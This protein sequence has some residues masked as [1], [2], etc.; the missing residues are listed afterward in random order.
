MVLGPRMAAARKAKG[1][2]QKELAAKLD[3]V[4]G[5][6]QQYELGK[7]RP[8]V[9]TLKNIAD[10]LQVSVDSLVSTSEPEDEYELICDTL[11]NAGYK[12][13]QGTVADEYYI[14]PVY[15]EGA[16]EI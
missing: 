5:T 10:I 4:T 14:S 6:V 8:D 15:A 2:T 13:E 12:I 9:E 11:D 7:R 1:L 16:D 3:L